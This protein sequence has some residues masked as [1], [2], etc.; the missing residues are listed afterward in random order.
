[1]FENKAFKNDAFKIK[2]GPIN[3]NPTTGILNKVS[4]LEFLVTHSMRAFSIVTLVRSSILRTFHQTR[5]LKKT[6]ET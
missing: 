6:A 5:I 2:T 3:F 1:M 4:L